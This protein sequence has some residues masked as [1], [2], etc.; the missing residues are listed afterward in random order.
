LLIANSILAQNNQL[1]SLLQQIKTD[2]DSSKVVNLNKIASGY[3][4]SNLDSALFYSKKAFQIAR[5]NNNAFLIGACYSTLAK[6]YYK[7]NQYD[8]TLKYRQL[9]LQER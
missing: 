9:S 4:L 3:S 6:I 5:K 1:D 2:N 8:K 7:N